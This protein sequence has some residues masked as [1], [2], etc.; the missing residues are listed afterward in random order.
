MAVVGERAGGHKGRG[1]VDMKQPPCVHVLHLPDERPPHDYVSAWTA[2]I[3]PRWYRCVRCGEVR[4]GDAHPY[5]KHYRLI[6]TPRRT[7]ADEA[8]TY[9]TYTLRQPQLLKEVSA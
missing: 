1:G 5:P 7:V 4:R 9:R 3:D 6:G 8:R 2:T